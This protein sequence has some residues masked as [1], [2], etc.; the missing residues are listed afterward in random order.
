MIKPVLVILAFIVSGV[1]GLVLSLYIHKDQEVVIST[2]NNVPITSTYHSPFSFVKQLKGDPD[3]GRKIFIEFCASCHAKEPI[4]DIKAPRIGDKKLWSALK[5][6]GMP[7]LVKLTSKG[8]KAMPARGGCFEC[9]DKQ[10]Q[11][12]IQYI[13]DHS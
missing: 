4:I 2:P 1:L 7:T 12:A 3:A 9:S 8:V 10:L 6:L 13:L 5:Q 11:E